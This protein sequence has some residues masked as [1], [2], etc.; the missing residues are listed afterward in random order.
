ME[1][2]KEGFGLDFVYSQSRTRSSRL[3]GQDATG[4]ALTCDSEVPADPRVDSLSTVPPIWQSFQSD[5]G[6]DTCNDVVAKDLGYQTYAEA[7]EWQNCDMLEGQ[8]RG[9]VDRRFADLLIKLN[10]MTPKNRC[11]LKYKT[12]EHEI[13]P[14][15]YSKHTSSPVNSSLIFLDDQD[16]IRFPLVYLAHIWLYVSA[17]VRQRHTLGKGFGYPT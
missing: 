12:V 14:N 16:S 15:A 13:V 17:C 4:A 3:S 5:H 11:D 7:T 6:R 8:F 1:N 10:N 9:H 2:V